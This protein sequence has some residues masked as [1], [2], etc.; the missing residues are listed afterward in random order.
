[1]DASPD[2]EQVATH[3]TQHDQQV[4]IC[5]D[6]HGSGI[7]KDL[8]ETVF[9]PFYTTKP[10]GQGTGLGLSLAHRIVEELGGRLTIEELP[11][12]GT[13]MRISLPLQATVNPS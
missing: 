8:Q 11:H 3:V 1:V 6:D 9:E 12:P 4:E 13:R 2:G 10:T 7:P 5:I